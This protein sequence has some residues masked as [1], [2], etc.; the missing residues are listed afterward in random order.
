MLTNIAKKLLFG[1]LAT[2]VRYSF[3]GGH[4]HDIDYQAVV[5]K[6]MKSGIYFVIKDIISIQTKLPEESQELL[7]TLKEQKTLRT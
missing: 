7:L 5:T 1:R 4:H 2:P 3:G 6:N